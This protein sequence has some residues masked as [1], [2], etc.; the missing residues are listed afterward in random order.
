M[1]GHPRVE[2]PNQGRRR[3]RPPPRGERSRRR[4]MLVDER[5]RHLQRSE[6]HRRRRHPVRPRS[7]S[8]LQQRNQQ[9]AGQSLRRRADAR[10]NVGERPSRRLAALGGL[11]DFLSGAGYRRRVGHRKDHRRAGS[12][13]R[14]RRH[15]ELCL[16][17]LRRVE[18]GEPRHAGG[19]E[20]RRGHRHVHRGG[21]MDRRRGPRLPGSH[22]RRESSPVRD[23]RL[24]PRHQRGHG[25]QRLPRGG[26]LR[27]HPAPGGATAPRPTLH[28]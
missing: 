9:P 23:R 18:G 4:T 25:G 12:G 28:L 11:D 1:G 6:D 13:I 22:P 14:R 27:R 17:D 20:L 8:E 5:R 2:S 21:S 16:V 7:G 10:R 19:E 3:Q 15:A 24:R 26:Q